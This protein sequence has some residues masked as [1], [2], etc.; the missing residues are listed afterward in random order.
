VF[1]RLASITTD[2]GID[3]TMPGTCFAPQMRALVTWGASSAV[4]S[5][6]VYVKKFQRN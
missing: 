2:L 4:P 5:A 3:L 6:R 1:Q